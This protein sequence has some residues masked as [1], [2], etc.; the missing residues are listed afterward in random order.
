MANFMKIG[1]NFSE[2]SCKI[3]MTNP[4]KNE[5]EDEKNKENEFDFLIFHIKIR[6]YRTFHKY[7]RKT[8]FLEIFIWEEDTKTDVSKGLIGQ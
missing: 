4:E 2:L 5:D 1:E 3:F 7:L 6:F 8:V